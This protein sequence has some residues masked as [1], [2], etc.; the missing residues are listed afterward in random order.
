M[1]VPP[2]TKTLVTAGRPSPTAR[3]I[4]VRTAAEVVVDQ[5]LTVGP[6]GERAVVAADR[7]ERD[8][9]VGA[10]GAAGR[11][12]GVGQSLAALGL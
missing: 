9:D 8:V 4:S 6:R 11:G 2:P 10:E 3:V 7:A 5:V 12:I 1:G